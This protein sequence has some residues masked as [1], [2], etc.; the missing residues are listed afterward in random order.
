MTET[1]LSIW[2]VY[3]HP[4]DFPDFFVARRWIAGSHG[5]RPTKDIL[6]SA[7]LTELRNE[8]ATQGLT[9]LCRDPSDDPKI[10]EVWL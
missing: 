10:V 7:D 8:L 2:T 1:E 4:R 3:D 6:L 9:A 5:E